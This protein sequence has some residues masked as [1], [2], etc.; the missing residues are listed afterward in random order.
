MALIRCTLPASD[1]PHPPPSPSFSLFHVTS[2]S[3]SPRVSAVSYT[4]STLYTHSH[5]PRSPCC[6]PTARRVSFASVSCSLSLSLSERNVPSIFNHT[7]GQRHAHH[8][9]GSTSQ[10][11]FAC[12]P[13]SRIMTA[14]PLHRI[15]VNA[16]PGTQFLAALAVSDLRHAICLFL[17]CC[18]FFLFLFLFWR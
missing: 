1:L 8:P 5:L 6:L 12:S 11:A 4:V 18:L 7:R 2:R 16:I 14:R 15:G 9:C 17:L 3:F 13:L 10:P